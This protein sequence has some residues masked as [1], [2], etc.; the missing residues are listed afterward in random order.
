MI[1][2]KKRRDYLKWLLTWDKLRAD[3]RANIEA[4]IE[5]YKELKAAGRE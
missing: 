4:A 1:K 3:T 2:S 5:H